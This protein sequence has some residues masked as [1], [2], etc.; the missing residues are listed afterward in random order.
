MCNGRL[1]GPPGDNQKNGDI[2]HELHPVVCKIMATASYSVVYWNITRGVW[3]VVRNSITAQIK[4]KE[5][6]DSVLLI[7]QGSGVST[8]VH[9]L[10]GGSTNC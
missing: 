9:R 10:W 8:A 3:P 2:S 7:V 6:L 1:I 4:S 5:K